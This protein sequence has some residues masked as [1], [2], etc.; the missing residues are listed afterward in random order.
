MKFML[1]LAIALG[2][3]AG[4]SG[5]GKRT[6]LKSPQAVTA[7]TP[8]ADQS[9]ETGSEADSSDRPFILDSLL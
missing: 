2:L 6:Q 8:A 9:S 7:E 4:L 5:C 1:T 3:A